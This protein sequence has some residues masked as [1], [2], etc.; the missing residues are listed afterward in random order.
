MVSPRA[1]DGSMRCWLLSLALYFLV[2]LFWTSKFCLNGLFIR[3]LKVIRF[4]KQFMPK[5]DPR[6]IDF[7]GVKSFNC[8]MFFL[9]L[10]YSVI[11]SVSLTLIMHFNSFRFYT[12]KCDV[13]LLEDCILLLNLL[14]QILCSNCSLIFSVAL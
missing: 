12:C 2:G 3:I 7:L 5:S 10:F 11:N 13:R 4:C 1:K 8:D 6:P 14:Y 9:K